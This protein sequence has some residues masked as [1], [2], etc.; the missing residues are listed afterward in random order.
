[1]KL[2]MELGDKSA[3]E[4]KF[5]ADA[6]VWS[7]EALAQEVKGRMTLEDMV[8]DPGDRCPELKRL[9]VM[10]ECARATCAR[11]EFGQ[12][13][14][15]RVLGRLELPLEAEFADNCG[16]TYFCKGAAAYNVALDAPDISRSD[17]GEIVFRC[18]ARE[19][20]VQATSRECIAYL[21]VL[22]VHAYLVRR[23][24]IELELDVDECAQPPSRPCRPNRPRPCDPCR[25]CKPCD[26]CDP[27]KPSCPCRP[28]P[29]AQA[30]AADAD[31]GGPELGEAARASLAQA[32]QVGCTLNSLA[33][34]AARSCGARPM[35]APAQPAAAASDED[36]DDAY[37][38]VVKLPVH[39]RRRCGGR[40]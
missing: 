10:D 26:P 35:P 27:C 38:T 4:L 5:F 15:A 30:S 2:K 37:R 11:V 29:R 21:L 22:D 25:P 24:L 34:G 6:V 33:A 12:D 39:R 19:L 31:E 13:G 17:C 16:N 20:T 23:E 8:P 14:T 40:N 7:G 36:D 18:E 28:Q 3:S 1:M 32:T 9:S